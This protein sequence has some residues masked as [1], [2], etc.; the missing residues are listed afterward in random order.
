M[1]NKQKELVFQRQIYRTSYVNGYILKVRCIRQHTDS[2]SYYFK[3]KFLSK[4]HAL[5]PLGLSA[6]YIFFSLFDVSIF[7]FKD[8]DLQGGG[9][10][11][12]GGVF[13]FCFVV[14]VFLNYYLLSIVLQLSSTAL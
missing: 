8:T 7:I 12:W 3:Q 1:P 14:W 2:V 13:C 4:I 10:V 6:F 11:S 9:V 5:L